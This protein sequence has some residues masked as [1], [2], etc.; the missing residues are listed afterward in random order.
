MLLPFMNK[1]ATVESTSS[2]GVLAGL[3]LVKLTGSKA[4][5][6]PAGTPDHLVESDQLPAEPPTQ[7]RGICA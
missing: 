2:T 4:A 7:E 6:I 1:L 5:G 3:V